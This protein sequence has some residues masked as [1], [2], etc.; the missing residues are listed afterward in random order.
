MRRS[1]CYVKYYTRED[2]ATAVKQLNNYPIRPGTQLAVIKSVDNRRLC[3]KTLP[4]IS[5]EITAGEVR[6][7][8]RGILE[9]VEGVRFI[10]TRWLE[11]E[12]QSHR[13]AALARRQ[14]LPGNITIFRT[15]VIRQVRHCDQ[16]FNWSWF[17]K[18]HLSLEIQISLSEIKVKYTFVNFNDDF[19]KY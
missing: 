9:G 7:E 3:I 13:L 1:Y 14:L 16:D 6:K 8:L 12:F 10:S 17:I 15:V 19:L 5:L 4:S 18:Q 2:A 11:V